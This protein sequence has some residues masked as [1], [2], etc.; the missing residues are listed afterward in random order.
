MGQIKFVDNKILFVDGKVCMNPDCC[1]EGDCPECR[2]GTIPSSFTVE[3][4]HGDAAPFE[5]Y[6]TEF[7][8]PCRPSDNA[9]AEYRMENVVATLVLDDSGPSCVWEGD[10][11]ATAYYQW[12][13]PIGGGGPCEDI[14]RRATVVTN[15]HMKMNVSS[16]TGDGIIW[17]L[18]VTTLGIVS[19]IELDEDCP[20]SNDCYLI[21]GVGFDI[22]TTE[23]VDNCASPIIFPTWGVCHFI[24][25]YRA[26]EIAVS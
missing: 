22:T 3:L 18:R 14:L 20:A 24:D 23:R 26:T 12:M 5:F 13:T 9:E 17:R 4:T 25:N 21:G 19:C 10:T 11:T 8:P 6:D 7:D 15:V 16:S 1:C 2:G